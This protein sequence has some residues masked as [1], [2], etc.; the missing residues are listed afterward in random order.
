MKRL[1]EKM[2]S[3][4][5]SRGERGSLLIFVLVVFS[6]M[7]LVGGAAIDLSRNETIRASLQYNLDR[8]V[9][10]AASLRQT[11]DPG[12]VVI[13]YM[14]R[15]NALT[16]FSVTVDANVEPNSRTVRATATAQMDTW[17]LNIAGINTMAISAA[18]TAQE[19]RPTLE[20][21]LVMDVSSS[22]GQGNKLSNLK[23]ATKDFVTTLMA[24][25]D[26]N[27]VTIS[28]VPFNNNVTPSQAMFDSLNVDQTQSSSTCLQFGSG[29]FSQTSIDP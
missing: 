7:I 26:P 4:K 2:L 20:I 18:S 10:A 22:M 17:F 15:V 8:A 25:A 28:V 19:K 3:K 12:D 24:N 23:G 6:G 27:T 14:S 5:I 16:D 21:S 11:Q 9:L 13:D 1:L 29:D